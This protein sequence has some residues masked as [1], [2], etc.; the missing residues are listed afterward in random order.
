M[1]CCR[2]IRTIISNQF[3]KNGEVGDGDDADGLCAME[4]VLV[5]RGHRAGPRP[6]VPSISQ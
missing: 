2:E 3:D 6:A 1:Y 5:I 4:M